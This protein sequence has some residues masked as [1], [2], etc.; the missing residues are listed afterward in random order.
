MILLMLF[1]GRRKEGRQYRGGET[2][3]GKWSYLMLPFQ[4][5]ERKGQHPF[6]K[7]KGVDE[8]ALSFDA[9]MCDGG[10]QS[11]SDDVWIDP[12]WKM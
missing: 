4:G 6:R 3:N 2:V 5:E 8:A 9:V 7:G 1:I 12:R 10:R 11:E